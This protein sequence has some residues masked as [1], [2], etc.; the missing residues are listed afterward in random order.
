M[1]MQPPDGKIKRIFLK[2]N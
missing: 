2:E 1:V